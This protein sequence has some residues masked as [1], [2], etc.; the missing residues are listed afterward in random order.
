MSA[1]QFYTA[2]LA[3][4]KVQVRMWPV[5]ITNNN[6]TATCIRTPDKKTRVMERTV[7]KDKIETVVDMLREDYIR[8]GLEVLKDFIATASGN[9]VTYRVHEM[10]N[11]DES[12]PTVQFRAFRVQ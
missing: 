10:L 6:E 12:E 2:R 1:S 5:T 11:D 8:L 9:P 3:E 4:W 7:F